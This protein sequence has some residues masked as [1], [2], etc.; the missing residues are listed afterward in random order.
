MFGDERITRVVKERKDY[1]LVNLKDELSEPTDDQQGGA[2]LLLP[3]LPQPI[4]DMNGRTLTAI[5]VGIAK[6]LCLDWKGDKPEWWPDTV[7]FS[8]PRDTPSE[9]KGK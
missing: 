9:Y 7:P 5:I 8:H 2:A 1:F 4:E 6:D 3:S